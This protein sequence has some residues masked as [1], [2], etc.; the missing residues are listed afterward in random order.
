MAPQIV[1]FDVLLLV[2]V[3]FLLELRLNPA[4]FDGMH[5]FAHLELLPFGRYET[6]LVLGSPTQWYLHFVTSEERGGL[7]F[8]EILDSTV[9]RRESLDHL[10]F[11][12]GQDSLL[13]GLAV[14]YGAPI[15]GILHL[16]EKL[17]QLVV[18]DAIRRFEY[19]LAVQIVANVR[20][21]LVPF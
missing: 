18:F 10:D 2:W 21:V 5:V 11:F 12:V 8:F 7:V 15:V 19:F 1:E 4:H 16:V 6:P 13:A 3:F 17:V 9:A 14:D 20:I